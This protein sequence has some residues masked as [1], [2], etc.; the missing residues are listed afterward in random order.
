MFFAVLALFLASYLIGSIPFGFLA[1][2]LIAGIDIR[3]VGSGNIGATNVGRTLGWHWFAVVLLLDALKG[4]GPTLAAV[5]LFPPSPGLAHPANIAVIAGVVAFLGHLYP[6]YLRFRGGKGM[7]TGLGL[8]LGLIPFTGWIPLVVSVG[9]FLVTLALTRFISLG[10]ML[11]AV[12]YA[13]AYFIVAVDP[14]SLERLGLAVLCI[15]VPPL[16]IWRHRQNIVRIWQ[17]K[18]LAVGRRAAEKKPDALP[19]QEPPTTAA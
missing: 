14:W 12:G 10:S 11:A 17:G 5:W 15:A 4:L 19:L 3:T 2:K 8:V 16:I 9:V 1:G 7:A 6:C 18:E 13:I